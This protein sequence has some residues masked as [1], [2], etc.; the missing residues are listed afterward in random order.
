MVPDS[1]Y[2]LDCD[3]LLCCDGYF[4]CHV[5]VC[6]NVT[7]TLL[8]VDGSGCV[9]FRDDVFRG[10]VFRAFGV[11]R[12]GLLG[13]GS[14][15]T[16][17]IVLWSFVNLLINLSVVFLVHPDSLVSLLKYFSASLTATSYVL[18]LG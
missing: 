1:G 12:R 10:C 11:L 13:L 18:D 15:L 2:S 6:G 4:H 14:I 17:S 9:L 3:G 8:D 5:Y 7:H 16:T